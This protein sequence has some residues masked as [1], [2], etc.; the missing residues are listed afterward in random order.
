MIFNSIF[1]QAT[2]STTLFFLLAAISPITP[3]Y[4]NQNK[5]EMINSYIDDLFA[6]N[7]AM[8]SY[9]ILDNGEVVLDRQTGY[10]NHN[11][12]ALAANNYIEASKTSRYKIAS[13]SKT[14]TATLVMQLIEEDKLELETKLADFFPEVK[15]ATSIS[16]KDMLQHRS[17]IVNYTD[18]P[19]FLNYY[20]K[21]QTQQKM[22]TRLAALP[23][24]FPPGSQFEYSNSNYLLLGYIVEKITGRPLSLTLRDRIT[25]PLNLKAASYCADL[26]A[27]GISISSFYYWDDTW[28][29]LTP[30]WSPTAA[31]GAGG[32]TSTTLDLTR[33]IHALSQGK[34]VSKQ[35]LTLM[36]QQ[37]LGLYSPQYSQ[38]ENY[39]H[40][41]ILEGYWSS[42][43]YFPEQD[44]AMAI[45]INGLHESYEDL[46]RNI[47]GLYFGENVK[48][49]DYDRSSIPLSEGQ[50]KTFTGS[51]ETLR[52]QKAVDVSIKDGELIAKMSGQRS[53]TF[54]PM[55]ENEFENRVYGVILTFN[56]VKNEHGKSNSVKAQI[57]NHTEAFYRVER[58]K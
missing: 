16:I 29:L 36:S 35:T 14:F 38:L 8:G 2:L 5:L 58:G 47:I 37:N 31:E 24:N 19:G 26:H 25:Q 54:T 41:G 30:Q 39:G 52:T 6:H 50:L 43:L 46:V 11:T 57:G 42:M 56:S 1:N 32:M 12:S 7:K 55:T 27:C 49:P 17:G 28:V 44:V 9:T 15:N 13:I 3:A 21:P 10:S 20:T 23:S 34:L 18:E 51:Y 33:F 4:A 53:F 40:D 22:L 48:L 45:S